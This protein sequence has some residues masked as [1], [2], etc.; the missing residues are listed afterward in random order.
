MRTSYLVVF[1]VLCGISLHAQPVNDECTTAIHLPSTESWC[2]NAGAYTNV[3]GTP[4]T[5]PPPSGA[6]CFLQYNNEVW[7]TFIPQTPALYIKVSGAVN[8]LGTLRNPAIGVFEG[9]CGSLKRVGCNIT[10]SVTNQVELSVESLVIGK[11]YYLL[12][13]GQNN[14][15]GTF[16]VCLDGFIPP[17]NPQSDCSRAVVLCDKSEFVVD[18]LLGVGIQD[19]GVTNTCIGQEFSSAWYKWTCEVSGSLT[20]TLIPN[21]YQQGFESDDI[22]FVVYELP[23]GIDDCSNKL[24]LR[25]MAAGA[26]TGLP[27]SNWVRCNGPTGLREG[28]PDI[29][30][31][32]GCQN[33]GQ[34]N[35]VD[36]L[37]IVAGKSYALLVNNFSQ[38]GL[39][40]SIEWGGTSIFKGPEPGFDVTAVQAFECDKTIIFENQSVANTDSI[41]HYLWNF[42]AGATPLSDTTTGP[43]SVVYESF[44][45]KKVALTV[46]SSKGCVVTEILDFYVEPCCK[47]TSTLDVTA[48]IQDQICPETATG[49]IQGVGISGSPEYQFSL[50]CI[51]YQP[52]SVFPSL[53]PG[54]YTLCIQDQKGCE[55]QVDLTVHPATGFG[56]EAGDTIFLELGEST[57][58]NA[59]PTPNLPDTVFWNNLNTLTFDGT[60]VS[61]LLNPTALPKRT[62]WYVVT[63]INDVGCITS[64]SVLIVVEVYK[65]IY[66]PNV[67]SANQDDINDRVTVYGNH[68]AK[69]FGVLQFQIFDRWGGLLWERTNFELNDPSLGWDG[70]VDGEPVN[71]GVYTYMVVVDFLDDIPVTYHGTVTVLR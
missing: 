71:P 55:N 4:Y 22:D 64:D 17:P 42:G 31:P 59:I 8:G 62:G 39:G 48:N 56:V 63:I 9:P 37:D 45:P 40:F 47:D 10:S 34:N 20:F 33:A 28:D 3:N 66:I 7:F 6:N 18:T 27:F 49:V 60:D 52:A 54:E 53:M 65:P 29:T 46:T 38:S 11:V 50:D 2:S 15:S 67:I 61:S 36:A 51:N 44:G 16:Q 5:G 69:V 43:I 23:N 1:L 70:T 57:E 35:F 24:E 32:A 19:P 30:E 68:A 25:C 14:F 41:V 21:N 13:E 58:L 12:V 26:N